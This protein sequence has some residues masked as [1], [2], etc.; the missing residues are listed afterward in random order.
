MLS[1][2]DETGEGTFPGIGIAPFPKRTSHYNKF[3]HFCQED[4]STGFIFSHLHNIYAK[5]SGNLAS[6]FN[7]KLGLSALQNKKRLPTGKMA[8]KTL[9]SGEI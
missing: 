7:K 2:R 6:F 1:G 3:P 8:G 5:L 9:L 4:Y